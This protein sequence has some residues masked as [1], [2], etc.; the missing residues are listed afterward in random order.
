M[1]FI[2]RFSF[3]SVAFDTVRRASWTIRGNFCARRAS[4]WNRSAERDCAIFLGRFGKKLRSKKM[5]Q[6]LGR[7]RQTLR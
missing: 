1:F 4:A 3:P 5:R 2:R 6:T 7:L